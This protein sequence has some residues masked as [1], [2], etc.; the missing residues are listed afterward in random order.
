MSAQ[1]AAY[2]SHGD[3]LTEGRYETKVGELKLLYAERQQTGHPEYRFMPRFPNAKLTADHK[4]IRVTYKTTEKLHSELIILNNKNASYL[5]LAPEASISNGEWVRSDAVDISQKGMLDRFLSKTHCTIGFYCTVEDA[6]FYVDEIAFFTSRKQAYTY[7]GDE[8]EEPTSGV[9]A[10]TFAPESTGITYN[11]ETYGVHEYDPELRALKITYAEKTNLPVNYMAKIKFT[12]SAPYKSDYRFIRVLYSAKNPEGLTGASM[13]LRTDAR[14]EVA[15]IVEEIRDTNGEFV[16]SD[17][18]LLS[19]YTCDRFAGTGEST[20]RTHN[21][22]FV[23]TTRE[24]GEYCIRAVYFFATRAEADAFEANSGN[25]KITVE[26]VDIDNFRIV[27]SDDAPIAVNYAANAVVSRISELCGVTLP[28]VTDK[29][30]QGEYEIIL[31]KCDREASTSVLARHQNTDYHYG[32]YV[33]YVGDK[34]IVITSEKAPMMENA[35]KDFLNN[36]LFMSSPISPK[37]IDI[38]AAD[39]TAKTSDMHV[40]EYWD[41]FENI[42]EPTI[43][44]DNFSSD[45]GLF[46]EENGASDFI[47]ANGT[48][49]VDASGD[50]LTYVH[51]YEPNAEISAK[52]NI[53]SAKDSG[54]ISLMLRYTAADAYVK[55]GYDYSLG[56]WF[57]E[58]REGS[59]FYLERLASKS[60]TLVKN[61]EHFLTFTANGDKLTL[62]VDGEAVLTAE[63]A[64]HVTPG[65]PALF[66]CDAKASFDDVK[67]VLLSGEGTVLYNTVHTALRDDTSLAGGTVI[68]M[69]DGTLRFI[70]SKTHNYI[71]KDNGMTWQEVGTFIDTYGQ[72][73]IV[74]LDNGSLLLIGKTGENVEALISS[75]D[76]ASF[77]K[78]GT[79]CPASYGANGISASATN[80]NDKI[81]VSPTTGRIHYCQN[82]EVFGSGTVDGKKV[83]CEFFYS[84]DNGATWTRSDTSSW[85]IEGNTEIEYFGE[86]KILECADGTLRMYNSWNHYGCIVYSESTD[87]GKTWGP[88]E[89]MP[90]FICSRSS[91]QFVRDTYAENDHTYY[92]VWVYSP[93]DTKVATMTRSRLSL[94]KSTDGKEWE[95]IGDLWRWESNYTGTGSHGLINHIVNPTVYVTEDKIIAGCG[96]SERMHEDSAKQFHQMQRQHLWTIVKNTL[97]E[98][99]RLNLFDDV[100]ITQ[101]YNNAVSF[102]TEKGLFNGISATTFAPDVTMNRAMFVT[103]LGR[104]DKA[105][106]SAYTEPTF[107]DVKQGEWYTAYVEWAAANGIVNGIGGGMYGV[108]GEVT[109]EQACTI[110]YRYANGK[111]DTVVDDILGVPSVSD[112]ADSASVSDWAKQAVEWA[113]SKGIYS[114]QNGSILPKSA[115]SRATVATMFANY[116]NVFG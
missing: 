85:E 23:N 41:K 102:V 56:E 107:S 88:L 43:I 73:N 110:L 15:C 61:S 3:N 90:E 57:I 81:F 69:N 108:T 64:T 37:V 38:K 94:A 10:M 68:K 66:V 45:I 49:S 112:F 28:I 99:K 100:K 12:A 34:S 62:S 116:V 7:Y 101:D 55:A 9:V 26:G 51:I 76:G 8:Y 19:Q 65:R 4:Y 78:V 11:G 2:Y 91:M 97:P 79:V 35:V 42:Q 54:E 105:D 47:I 40:S 86:C 74:R 72:P 93:Y 109:V 14:A 70:Y 82:Y 5:T 1:G 36:F 60:A 16:L 22:L 77:K 50:K 13:M 103:V 75:D 92:M 115:A 111:A 71:S 67:I 113:V 63:G 25:S 53:S 58:S 52:V 31:G 104:L 114:G 29:E 30:P 48:M 21:S 20:S 17:T 33:T 24:G 95:Y 87:G 46:T 59:D 6:E 39:I 44:T 89:K 96:A 83:F 27:I 80:M 84:D 32:R 98:G 106:V 18:V